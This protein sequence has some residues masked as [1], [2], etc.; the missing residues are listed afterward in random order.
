[1]LQQPSLVLFVALAAVSCYASGGTKS[2]SSTTDVCKMCKYSFTCCVQCLMCCC[3][4]GT[5][6][7]LM[8]APAHNITIESGTTV[9]LT[10]SAKHT[11]GQDCSMCLVWKHSNIPF[12]DVNFTSMD[13][14]LSS[15]LPLT[16]DM[17]NQGEYSCQTSGTM[18][19]TVKSVYITAAS[20]NILSLA[21]Q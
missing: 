14:T 17:N 13:G 4:S 9:S 2:S 21:V 12:S 19:E 18:T 6:S 1:M 11:S 5:I 3:Y 10:C 20:E 8:I 15:T 16:V 7:E